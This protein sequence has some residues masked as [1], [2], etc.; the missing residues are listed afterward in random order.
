MIGDAPTE[1]AGIGI[2]ESV[3]TRA[4]QVLARA[5]RPEMLDLVPGQPVRLRAEAQRQWDRTGI[6]IRGGTPPVQYRL[7]WIGGRWRDSQCPPCGPAG[8]LDGEH[9]RD[10]R[11]RARRRRRLRDAPWMTLC[12]TIAGPRRWPLRELPLGIGLAYLWK[13]EPRMLLNQVAPLGRTMRAEGDSVV[14]RSER[15]PGML[16]LFA[17][18]LWQTYGNN[19]GELELEITRL[20]GPPEPG[21]TVWVLPREGAWRVM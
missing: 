21:E 14:I 19:A 18:D 8:N 13:R 7:R 2:H 10:P 5:G 11:W 12:A 16:Y 1:N 17:N 4:E 15:P 20:D 3:F 6:I 9:K